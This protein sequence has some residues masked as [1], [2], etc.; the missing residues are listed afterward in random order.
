VVCKKRKHG[1]VVDEAGF[2]AKLQK[3]NGQA[4]KKKWKKKKKGRQELSIQ[5]RI[6]GPLGMPASGKGPWLDKG[7]PAPSKPNRRCKGK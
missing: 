5:T 3:K 7:E 1:T 6:S 2:G 4:G